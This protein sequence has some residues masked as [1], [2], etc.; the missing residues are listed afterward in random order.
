M[1]PRQERPEINEE[2]CKEVPEFVHRLRVIF[3]EESTE[4]LEVGQTNAR[5]GNKWELRKCR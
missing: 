2:Y 1:G 3:T 4:G 5:T